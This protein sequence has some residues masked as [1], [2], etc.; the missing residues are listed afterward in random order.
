MVNVNLARSTG[1]L[2]VREDPEK[3]LAAGT[4]APTETSHS[5]SLRRLAN[6]SLPTASIDLVNSA[7]LKL[8][9]GRV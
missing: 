4:R 5:D 7:H 9:A 8:S 1:L 6:P 3:A 2:R